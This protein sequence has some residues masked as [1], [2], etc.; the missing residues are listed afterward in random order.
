MGIYFAG[1]MKNSRLMAVLLIAVMI[2]GFFVLP[3]FSA[4][5]VADDVVSLTLTLSE[6][7]ITVGGNTVGL[8]FDKTVFS[9]DSLDTSVSEGRCTAEFRAET[10]L[11]FEY[12]VYA[13]GE[14]LREAG[15]PVVVINLKINPDAPPGDY[16]ILTTKVPKGPQLSDPTPSVITVEAGGIDV[17]A[18]YGGRIRKGADGGYNVAVDS[19]K[20]GDGDKAGY[21]IDQL[22]VDGQAIPAASGQT[23]FQVTADDA[24]TRS[25]VALFEYT[26][27]FNSPLNGTLS[28]KRGDTELTSGDIVRGGEVLTV[29]AVAD[30]GYIAELQCTGLTPAGDSGQYI[31]TAL[32][33]EPA[34]EIGATFFP[35]GSLYSISSDTVV[36]GVLGHPAQAVV[37]AAVTVTA[38]P[39]F[40]FYLEDGSLVYRVGA[41]SEAFLLTATATP[42]GYEFV[43]PGDSVTLSAVFL[44]IARTISVD[45]QPARGS[46]VVSR[47][48]APVGETISLTIQPDPGYVTAGLVVRGDESLAPVPLADK[49]SGGYEFVM[50][51]EPVTVSL[52]FVYTVGQPPLGADGFYQI[53]TAEHF[54]WFARTVN[55][56]DGGINAVLL[57][58]LDLTQL[59][60]FT[61][62]GGQYAAFSNTPF[63]GTFDGAGHTLTVDIDLSFEPE[64]QRQDYHTVGVFGFIGLG[65]VVRDLH[66]EGSVK[67]RAS[68]VGGIVGYLQGGDIIG[69]TFSGTVTSEEIP[70][71]SGSWLAGGIVASVSAA[72][73]GDLSANRDATITD[74]SVS[75]AIC[76]SGTGSGGII[77]QAIGNGTFD[78]STIV[79]GCVNEADV[80]GASV[81]VGGIV[82]YASDTKII[83]CRNV[84]TIQGASSFVGGIV[85]YTMGADEIKDCVN[86]G[87]VS[88]RSTV[89]GIAGQMG[90]T[91]SLS[92]CVNSG[93]VEAAAADA[94]GI[95]GLFGSPGYLTGCLN[96]GA[97]TATQTRAGGITG[98]VDAGK[99]E[100]NYNGGPVALNA[101]AGSGISFVGGIVGYFDGYGFNWTYS[102]YGSLTGSYNTGPVVYTLEGEDVS[103]NVGPV[104]GAYNDENKS[105]IADNY[106]A[107]DDGAEHWGAAAVSGT[108]LNAA[109]AI[110]E[111]VSDEEIRY[112]EGGYPV[113]LSLWDGRGSAVEGEQPAAPL[114]VLVTFNLVPTNAGVVVIGADDAVL[115]PVSGRSYRLTQGETYAYNISADG[116]ETVSG[117]LVPEA[118]ETIAIGL[119]PLSAG[120]YVPGWDKWRP[121]FGVYLLSRDGKSGTQLGNWNYDEAQGTYVGPDSAAPDFIETFS[122][123]YIYSGNDNLPGARLG[124]VLRGIP[125]SELIAWYNGHNG[126]A[127]DV[128]ADNY[129]DYDVKLGTNSTSS[130]NPYASNDPTKPGQWAW[131][132]AFDQFSGTLRYYYPDFL[133]GANSG[134]AITTKLLGAGEL[135]DSVIAVQSYNDRVNRLPEAVVGANL[136]ID[137][138][139]ELDAA[140]AY[141]VG[142]ADTERALRNF[143]GMAPGEDGRLNSNNKPLGADG[144]YYIGSVWFAPPYHNIATAGNGGMVL[145]GTVD[146]PKALA[147]E[148]VSFAVNSARN[149]TVVIGAETLTP[150]PDGI[151]EFVMPDGDVIVNIT[152]EDAPPVVEYAVAVAPELSGGSLIPD[153]AAA[154]AGETVTVS[155]VPDSGQRLTPGSLTYN[156]AVVTEVDGVY[157]F[158][159]PAANVTLSAVFAAIPPTP[160]PPPPPTE[161]T[162]DVDAAVWDGKS[163]DIRWFDPEADEYHISTPAQLAGLAALVNGLY[164]EE[165]DTI[166]GD[167]LY[168]VVNE[169]TAEGD[170]GNNLSTATYHF[171]AYDFEDKTVYLDADV[172]MGSANYMPI[173]GQ[174]LMTPNDSATRIDASFSG[175]FDGQGHKVTLQADRHADGNYGDGQ[176]VGL[177]GRLGVHDDDPWELR[178]ESPAVRNLTITGYIHA[179]RSVGG[180]VGKI[181]KTLGGVVI[182]NVANYATVSATDAK[183]VGG[184]V[185]A[186]WNGG[187]IR[188][189]Y[190]AGAVS[191]THISPVGGIAGSV[192]I[193]IINSYNIGTVRGPSSYAMAL[194]T[195]NGGAPV[196]ENSYYLA[197]SA[198][199]GGWF[200]GSGRRDNSGERSA[201]FMRSAEFVALLGPAFAADS[202]NV[203]G[204]YPVL[205]FGRE[206]ETPPVEIVDF[207]EAPA[208]VGVDE[209]SGAVTAAVTVAVSAVENAAAEAVQQ[210]EEALAAGEENV[211]A[212]VEI[213]VTLPDDAPAAEVNEVYVALPAAAA[214]ALLDA[215]VS[216][217][218]VS[219][220]GTIALDLAAL[221]AAVAE[222]AAGDTGDLNL[223]LAQ[224]TTEGAEE[225]NLQPPA[226]AGAQIYE[227]SL[228]YVQDDTKYQIT[229]F[230]GGQA[231]VSLPYVLQAGEEAAGVTVWYVPTGDGEA[232]SV[233][234]RY[235][236]ATQTVTFATANLSHYYA[237][238]YVAPAEPPVEPPAEPP[239][240]P[241]VEPPTEPETPVIKTRPVPS[242]GSGAALIQ[243]PDEAVPLAALPITRDM[244]SYISGAD[245]VLTS[246]AISR[247]GW[248]KAAAVI[249]AP[250][251]ANNLVD[252]LAVAPLAGQAGAPILLSTGSLDPAVVAEIERLGA[253]KVYAVGALSEAVIDGL[254]AAL[255]QVTVEVL[256]GANRFETA[257]LI[258]AKVENPQGTFIVGYNALADAVSVASYAAAH[259]YLIQIAQPDGTLATD[260]YPLPTDHYIIGGPAL[261]GDI[262]GATR[263]Y[264]PDRY[265][266][267]LAVRQALDY[268][269]TNI[270]T[271]DGA[272]LVDALTGSALAARSGAAIVLTPGND[273]AGADFGN[274]TPETKVYAFGEAK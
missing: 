215:E 177:I 73:T 162:G 11:G 19:D 61:T 134:S 65:G 141:M 240:E 194:G 274:I 123:P 57:N 133:T 49:G 78:L 174:Y 227:V 179:N 28:V 252:A 126:A 42:A 218:V 35:L 228:Y 8:E 7:N 248:E 97:V 67:G 59:Q 172:D 3:D 154:P 46:V 158:T 25:I 52:G 16:T 26:V 147:G 231:T 245:R 131:P 105:Y 224:V 187:V 125:A 226:D 260:H 118:A 92:A 221:A 76:G 81:R 161:G 273:P 270:Y 190:N 130:E 112:N 213:R 197:G 267:N 175:T 254:R 160:P 152:L 208:V 119:K 27:N 241:P 80:F 242:G 53:S 219:P 170:P 98:S 129:R 94:G 72:N 43:M 189:A 256:R 148:T 257:A 13:V 58:D 20:L 249:I 222:T 182:E 56:G 251:G 108:N 48:T 153:R 216:V 114:P 88:G 138:K 243:A 106:Y 193:P 64:P 4:G 9:F 220:T 22:F 198:A 6:R 183:G 82:G 166:A 104:A 91:G 12:R 21:V 163:L 168:L 18:D 151:Y 145:T 77:G 195:N 38:Q 237:V 96:T 37:G 17:V 69:C 223:V 144:S 143:E 146:F 236:A 44:P 68:Y 206:A 51:A 86:S 122:S 31:V 1:S 24:P 265:A 263:L 214:Q 180:I 155:V 102:H 191:G 225:N 150:D 140:I 176:S 84:G 139:S 185:G 142:A 202:E 60:P 113:P 230:G 266:T 70:S 253:T 103:E 156:G 93:P 169:S 211:T 167:P 149:A 107:P 184:I 268:E 171:G 124:V 45:C 159:M 110:L 39:N 5:A 40:G 120:Q 34:P 188:N 247:A 74:C 199:D 165:I 101:G 109:L 246:V 90:G 157:S 209:A 261:V 135:R 79:S 271:A 205:T 71:G 36:H 32:R 264:G 128:T 192:E 186:A 132:G 164:N 50:P 15:V 111:S 207:V 10:D 212:T 85:G 23:S 201:E 258:G 99:L 83:D 2:L 181:G 54:L 244:V 115:P 116:Y 235:D 127:P 136:Q 203:N 47:D 95:A 63:S 41:D 255:P 250:G 229:D 100:G 210:A 204:G 259:G 75:G 55:D 62:I 30:S 89:G 121:S 234:A 117:T 269:Y 196:P 217:R 200:L 233:P 29:E 33:G 87:A 137:N 272:S 239:V 66:V 232:A 173:G 178:A 262:P 14:T 238:G